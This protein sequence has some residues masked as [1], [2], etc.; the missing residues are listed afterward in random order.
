MKIFSP[1][2][3]AKL[4]N[5]STF[6]QTEKQGLMGLLEVLEDDEIQDLA[7]TLDTNVREKEKTFAVHEAKI[8]Q[9]KLSLEMEFE[10]L[11]NGS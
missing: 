7:R 11:K 4:L 10:K 2:D 5:E 1:E 9:E 6:S 3:F 8:K